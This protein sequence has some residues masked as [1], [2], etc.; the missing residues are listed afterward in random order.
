MHRASPIVVSD[1][2][3]AI[4]RYEGRVAWALRALIVAGERGCTPIDQPGPR[5]AHYVFCLRRDGIDVET[6]HERHGGPFPGT[7][8]RYI[9]RTPLTVVETAAAA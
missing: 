8:A 4:R 2:A 9:L 5:W 1:A 3:G 7:H 6:I